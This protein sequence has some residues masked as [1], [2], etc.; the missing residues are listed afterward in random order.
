MYIKC[1]LLKGLQSKSVEWQIWT[2]GNNIEN[3]F[4]KHKFFI[5]NKE[6]QNLSYPQ[7]IDGLTFSTA[8]K[9]FKQFEMY[10]LGTAL[11]EIDSEPKSSKWTISIQFDGK[12]IQNFMHFYFCISVSP[13]VFNSIPPPRIKYLYL[14]KL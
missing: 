1:F 2:N 7:N 9:D 8:V 11:I 4:H 12:G 13:H 14:Q 5:N 6:I 3:S 10:L